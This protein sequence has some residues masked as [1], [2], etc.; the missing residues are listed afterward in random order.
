MRDPIQRHAAE[1]FVMERDAR[2][3]RTLSERVGDTVTRFTGS[4]SFVVAH[5][6]LIAG[7]MACNAGGGDKA[8]DPFPFIFL[9]LFLSAEAIFLSSFVLISQNRMQRLA[10]HW[11]QIALMVN[12]AAADDAAEG[13]A[14]AVAAC[15]RLG[16]VPGPAAAAGII[17]A[18]RKL[19]SRG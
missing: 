18:A 12:L 19:D 11:S 1:L 14:A 9:N 8:L 5:V 7:W 6:G 10:D 13:R 3:S 16:A 15:H 17:D 4:V 2:K